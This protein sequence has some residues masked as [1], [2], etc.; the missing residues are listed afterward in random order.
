M[1]VYYLDPAHFFSALNLNWEAML[2][3]TRTQLALLTDI[4]LLLFFEKGIR[5]EI[6][7]IGELQHFVTN[8]KDLDS[9]DV[10]QPS[11]YGAFFDVTS[12]CA[13]TMQ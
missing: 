12:L 1:K 4:D 5:G 3:T 6:N 8:N 10:S 9:F 13:G 7:G 2:I 11:V